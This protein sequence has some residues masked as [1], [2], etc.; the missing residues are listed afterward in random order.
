M[1]I[2]GQIRGPGRKGSES[3]SNL[4]I[5]KKIPEEREKRRTCSAG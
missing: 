3:L 5:R 2:D 1:E 4:F